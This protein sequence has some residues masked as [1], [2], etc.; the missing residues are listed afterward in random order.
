MSA[1]L[2]CHLSSLVFAAAYLVRGVLWLRVLS[3]CG[4][5]IALTFNYL[6]PATP[7]WTAMFWNAVFIVVNAVSIGR[8]L[9]RRRA[10]RREERGDCLC[11]AA[12]LHAHLRAARKATG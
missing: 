5:S 10:A 8:T 3:V 1:H 11:A 6:A 4:C 7:L 12:W 9:A 2:L